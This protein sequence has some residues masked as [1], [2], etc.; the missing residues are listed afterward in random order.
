MVRDGCSVLYSE[1]DDRIHDRA[2]DKVQIIN[3]EDEMEEV[4]VF[5]ELPLRVR[6]I[7]PM[8][9]FVIPGGD[10]DRWLHVFRRTERT[11][12]DVET[13][14]NVRLLN[15]LRSQKSRR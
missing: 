5:K 3:E 8:E 10:K 4:P 9:M 6:A 12:Y 2:Q 15:M 14:Y 13:A 11:V 1:W 7:D